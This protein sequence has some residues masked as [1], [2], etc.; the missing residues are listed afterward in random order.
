MGFVHFPPPTP[1]VQIVFRDLDAADPSAWFSAYV[2]FVGEIRRE[3]RA[4]MRSFDCV[5]GWR[6][7]TDRVLLRNP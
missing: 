5:H 7:C 3:V 6:G 2:A 4:E 1:C